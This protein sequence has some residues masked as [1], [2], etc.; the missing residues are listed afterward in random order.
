MFVIIKDFKTGKPKVIHGSLIF[1]INLAARRLWP[2]QPGDWSP[3]SR[4]DKKKHYAVVDADVVE[5]TYVLFLS[6]DESTC[7]SALEGQDGLKVYN[8][9]RH[10]VEPFTFPLAQFQNEL[11]RVNA[12][13][14]KKSLKRLNCDLQLQQNKQ[15][16]KNQ[17]SFDT[18]TEDKE[19]SQPSQKKK[20]ESTSKVD[21]NDA[22]KR[23]K[24][25]RSLQVEH[26][27]QKSNLAIL[28]AADTEDTIHD[29]NVT[30]QDDS[31]KTD[32]SIESS[33]KKCQ[34]HSEPTLQCASAMGMVCSV[35]SSPEKCHSQLEPTKECPAPKVTA[36]KTCEDLRI[37][38]AQLRTEKEALH[39]LLKGKEG[40]GSSQSQSVSKT[41]AIEGREVKCANGKSLSRHQ[42]A[43]IE[44][45]SIRVSGRVLNLARKLF[46]SNLHLMS[47]DARKASSSDCVI[48]EETV[49]EMCGILN[50]MKWRGSELA[51]A[52]KVY[53]RSK[54]S[55]DPSNT[56]YTAVTES[57]VRF[58]LRKALHGAKKK[59]K[60]VIDENGKQEDNTKG[61]GK[62][63]L[64]KNDKKSGDEKS[65]AKSSDEEKSSEKS[66]D[67]KSSEK[68]SDEE[69]SD[70]ES[71][72]ESD[73]RS[74]KRS[75]GKSDKKSDKK[76]YKESDKKIDDEESDE[77]ESDDEETGFKKN[78]NDS[79]SD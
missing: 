38:V 3:D 44:A 33:V 74:D 64:D 25:R 19:N 61:K 72:E 51:R 56:K 12:H 4:K 16:L 23:R 55:V 54:H 69:S 46:P 52:F 6:D 42:V 53:S 8:P 62:S 31:I 58:Y 26:S 1:N 39:Q 34:S 15:V 22:K 50:S 14:H 32:L 18:K 5:L 28:S 76:S 21:E 45:G 24:R 67:E 63:A 57:L 2:F 40:N 77:E 7:L 47:L 37:E 73:K 79:C 65:S 41:F 60:S 29:L 68:S 49:G 10:S 13:N 43:S 20:K 27:R 30:F 48:S 11:E 70:E 36:C 78:G 66:S 75:D 71:D 9:K 35:K 59:F 17:D